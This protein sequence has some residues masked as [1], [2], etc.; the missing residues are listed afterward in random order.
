MDNEPS[1]SSAP[2]KSPTNKQKFELKLMPFEEQ[3]MID[4]YADDLVF[5]TARQ[6]K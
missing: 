1:T 4:T 3:L 6:V 5:I 2:K